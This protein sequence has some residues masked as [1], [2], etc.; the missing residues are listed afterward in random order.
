MK[1]LNN[2]TEPFCWKTAFRDAKPQW[3]RLIMYTASI[4]AGVAALVAILSFRADI[5]NTVQDQS[6]ELLG[7]DIELE[8]NNQP[9]PDSLV[10][11]IDT[12]DAEISTS[13]EFSSMVV[14][15]DDGQTRLSQIRGIDGGFPFY[16]E[17]ET[18]PAEAASTFQKE[19]GA[20]VEKSALTQFGLTVGDSIKVG[21]VTLPV[22]GELISVPGEAAALALIGPRV[23]VSADILT[24][25]G[26]L[27]R[28]SRLEYKTHLKFSNDQDLAEALTEMRPIARNNRIDI[29]TVESR[30]QQFSE[31]VNNLS[32][33]L[34][35]IGLI[36]LL[37]GGLGVASAMYVYIKKKME[38]VATL[39]C[40]GATSEQITTIFVLQI[41][42]MA[43]AGSII[44]AAIGVGFQLYLP[45]LFV[46]FLPFEISQ[47]FSFEAV[48]IGLCLGLFTSLGFAS[49]P[50]AGSTKISPLLTLR[51]LE[52]SPLQFVSRRMKLM[53]G[54]FTFL[55]VSLIVGFLLE[56]YLSG[57]IFCSVLILFTLILLLTSRLLMNIVQKLRLRSFSY[58]WRQGAANLFRPNNQTGLLTTTIGMGVLLISTLYLSQDMIVNTIDMQLSDDAPN[59]VFYD[60]Q[61]DQNEGV[62]DIIN[63][64]ES[65]IIQ[66]VPIV[67]MRLQ[68]WKG[69][70]I[71]DVRSDTTLSL[72]RWA[73]TRE[74]RVTYR[75]H[76]R[77]SETLVEGDW[78]G[79]AEGIDSV[80]PISP[81]LRITEDLNLSIGDS[82]TFDVQGVSVKTVVA[83]IREVDF[84]RPEPN[85][86]IV[87]PNGVL[88]PAPQ[89]FATV[90][91][92][93]DEETAQK[94]Q[95]NVVAQYPN[96]SALD[97]GIVLKSVQ[98]FLD[99]ISMAVQFMAFFTILT[100]FIVLASS[101]SLSK[102]QRA[103][104]SVLLRTLGA[105][106][107]QISGI[108]T[109]E[110]ILL[111]VLACITG[112]ILSLGGGYLLA[113]FYFDV[114]FV[115]DFA[116]IAPLT[117]FVILAV[118]AMG[119][120]GS[121][122]IFKQTPLEVL[123]IEAT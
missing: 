97:I 39:R 16:G 25:S 27:Q 64:E 70:D 102:N 120:F 57:F 92:A 67:S 6:R 111:G 26:L 4:I 114:Q 79:E 105:G 38:T 42:V 108:Q 36:A 110:Y 89:F 2:L 63:M 29:D 10:A 1:Y 81:A 37:L 112:L 32:K 9:L 77:E 15:G 11:I 113:V 68:K 33:F 66:N 69:R 85:F 44:G 58:I 100:G 40:L 123:R 98:E 31:I 117:L 12:L 73:L 96:V 76:L 23:Y 45:S 115:P 34:G 56:N 22:T 78:I 62:L 121:R 122:H 18:S 75:D 116:I 65:N 24:D 7:A 104:E 84:Q 83:S 47:S 41:T 90:L 71:Q 51:N 14:Y 46:D 61:S 55:V 53:V 43:L 93:Q 13:V 8:S 107:V 50:I 106:K 91:R 82:L 60:I 48:A 20:L 5:F 101:L 59:L 72:R 95:Q 17:I 3:K 74:Y 103:Q 80:V 119:W 87:F 21:T 94:L 19:K 54:G 35:L 49:L 118:I 30:Q 88:E 28:G 109:V 99:K 52:Q 86:F